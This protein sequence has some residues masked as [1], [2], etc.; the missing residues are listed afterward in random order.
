MHSELITTY[1]ELVRLH[2]QLQDEGARYKN[3]I[4]ALLSVL[5]PEVSEVFIDS[6][7]PTA[8]GL[9]KCYPSAQAIAATLHEL[10]PRNCRRKTAEQFVQLANNL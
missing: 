5:F 1:R 4:H 3:E 6:C 7:R 10:A 2:T 8:L 9:L